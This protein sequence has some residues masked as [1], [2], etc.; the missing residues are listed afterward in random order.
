MRDVRKERFLIAGCGSIGMRHLKNLRDLGVSNF[1]LLDR[2]RARLR[3][4]GEGLINPSFAGSMEEALALRPYCAVISVPTSLHVELARKA[5]S[6]G[7]HLFIEKPLSHNMDGIEGLGA[8]ASKK[9]LTVM[10]AMCYR[11]HPVLRRIK[12]RLDSGLIGCVYHVNYFGGFYLPY[13]HRD[14]DYRTGYAARAELGGGVVL[15]SIHGLDTLRWLFGEVAEVKAFT[16][17][18]SPLE[19][20]VEDLALAVMRL[21]SGAYVN[22]QTDFL[23]RADQHRMLIV[24]EKGTMRYDIMRGLEEICL[25]D[26]NEGEWQTETIPFDVNT[27]YVQELEHFVRALEAESPPQPG[28]SDGIETL[29]LAMMVTN[30]AMAGQMREEM[31]A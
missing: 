1:I 14:E 18:V 29:K 22:W 23:Q 21:F 6:R 16:A 7:V 30:S 8:M 2:D 15:T 27:M 4:A 20:D 25:T 3:A 31:R 19:M 17:K 11:F 26:E 24:G 28:L 9:G 13:W 5:A 10:M 12:E